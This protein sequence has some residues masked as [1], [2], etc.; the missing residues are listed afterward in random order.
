MPPFE[1]ER[2]LLTPTAPNTTPIVVAAPEQTVGNARVLT[3]QE[4]S[5]FVHQPF[6]LLMLHMEM[7]FEAL[8]RGA[9][10][11]SGV[12]NV[13]RLQ[14]EDVCSNAHDWDPPRDIDGR[15]RVFRMV[16][17][18][19]QEPGFFWYALTAAPCH[20]TFP[21]DFRYHKDLEGLVAHY[22]KETR[23]MISEDVY[24]YVWWH[25]PELFLAIYHFT[26]I[27]EKYFGCGAANDSPMQLR[28]DV[29]GA[30]MREP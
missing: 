27:Y 24:D 4:M 5:H 12:S 14:G 18:W 25:S 1:F 11:M 28:H 21:V 26:W 30:V 19:S 13:M 7:F 8:R 16:R 15:L 17:Q 3:P 29:R 2:H 10:I 9:A 20:V 6:D 22:S 23:D